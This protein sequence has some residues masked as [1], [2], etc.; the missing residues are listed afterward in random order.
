MSINNS[1]YI[2][3]L[4]QTK[5]WSSFNASNDTHILYAGVSKFRVGILRK[6]IVS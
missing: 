4:A 6:A 5:F 3:R 2:C 1:H